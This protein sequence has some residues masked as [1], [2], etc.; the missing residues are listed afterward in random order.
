ML[1][2]G[3]GMIARAFRDGG[4]PTAPGVVFARGVGNSQTKDE[5][6]YTRERDLLSSA[7]GRARKLAEPLVYFSG[8]PI[9][10]DFSKK[11]TESTPCRPVTRYGQHQVE[12]E[13]LIRQ[14]GTPYIIARLPNV[15]GAPGNPHQLIPAFVRQVLDG[16]VRVQNSAARDLIDAEDVVRLVSSLL[17]KGVQNETVNVASGRS[18]AASDIVQ[19]ISS[20]LQVSPCIVEV[21]GGEAQCFDITRLGDLVGELP[22]DD[23]YTVRTIERY[24][25]RI[26]AE[27][28]C[29]TPR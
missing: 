21:M 14:S 25:S 20:Q 4:D 2:D 13:A 12:C 19:V 1:V 23:A 6:P 17:K 7:L 26:A 3:N 27:M 9:Y 28:A 5:S 15:V 18:I 29:G 24:A 10:G 11:V 22:F 8:A 16:A